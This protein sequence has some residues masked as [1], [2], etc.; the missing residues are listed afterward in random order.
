MSGLR[1]APSGGDRSGWRGKTPRSTG[2]GHRAREIIF[3]TI[4]F[5]KGRKGIAEP[6]RRYLAGQ[7]YA[8]GEP[9]SMRVDTWNRVRAARSEGSCQ[10]A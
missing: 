9:N 7:Q 8:E 2:S 3:A 1:E 5:S 10:E 4:S 6:M